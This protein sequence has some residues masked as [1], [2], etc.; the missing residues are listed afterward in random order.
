MPVFCAVIHSRTGV[1]RFSPLKLLKLLYSEA[2]CSLGDTYEHFE[3]PASEIFKVGDI[4]R[5][6]LQNN[7][8][9]PTK[10]TVPHPRNYNLHYNS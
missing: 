10:Y 5:N 4:G 6:F 3:E 9:C 7:G 2:P 8:V 1:L